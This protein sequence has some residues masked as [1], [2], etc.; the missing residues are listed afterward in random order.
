MSQMDLPEKPERP[1][2]SDCCN[3]GCTPCILD[4]YEDL[5]KQW[6]EKCELIKS[7]VSVSEEETLE[8]PPIL[9]QTRYATFKV[10]S[11]K[12]VTDD[13]H[14]YSLQAV[15]KV[16]SETIYKDLKFKLDFQPSQYFVLQARDGEKHFTRAYT[17]IS[18][19][20][21]SLKGCFDVVIKI[22]PDGKMSKYLKNLLL[23]D[24]TYWR[25]P[26]GGF[27]YKPNTFNKLLMLCAGTGIA[28]L[29]SLAQSI[30]SNEIDETIIR[31]LYCCKDVS[32]IILRNEIHSLCSFWN[33]SADI[34]VPYS[35]ASEFKSLYGETLKTVRLSQNE[36]AV[37]L[38]QKTLRE[39]MI[40]ICGNTQFCQDMDMFVKNCNADPKQIHIF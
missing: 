24:I 27:S 17:P 38:N 8:H 9:S 37:E 28:P 33:F 19:C 3:S 35:K 13:T 5:V 15:E 30:V 10:V 23:G 11:I 6:Q 26:Y 32:S 2:P 16:A 39:T 7:G 36:I 22:Y 4:V 20:K 1:L 31:M 21:L 29:Y 34:Y 14:L 18:D 12:P 25:G 40:F